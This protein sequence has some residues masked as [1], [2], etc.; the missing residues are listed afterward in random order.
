VASVLHGG[1]KGLW[2][3]LFQGGTKVVVEPEEEVITLLVVKA[4]ERRVVGKASWLGL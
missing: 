3:V 2:K 4:S 1:I